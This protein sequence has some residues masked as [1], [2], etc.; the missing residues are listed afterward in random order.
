M[1]S[2]I[3][4]YR[5]LD[6]DISLEFYHFLT[7]LDQLYSSKLKNNL[8]YINFRG[9]NLKLDISDLHFLERNYD[10]IIF[11]LDIQNV[12][13]YESLRKK[14]YEHWLRK[15]SNKEKDHPCYNSFN[16]F[17]QKSKLPSEIKTAYSILGWYQPL[18]EF[19]HLKNKN[20]KKK[21]PF[22]L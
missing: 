6:Y 9:K 18:S 11:L 21:V 16:R 2:I 10:K 22:S 12:E 13:Y 4:W 3:N 14:Q 15:I 8:K 7:F 5:D 17:V 1:L 19:S 20:Y